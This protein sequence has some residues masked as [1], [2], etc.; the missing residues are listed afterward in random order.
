MGHNIDFSK[1][2]HEKKDNVEESQV[3]SKKDTY[4]DSDTSFDYAMLNKK[5]KATYQNKKTEK[6]MVSKTLEESTD[7]SSKKLNK[8]GRKRK[9]A[10]IQEIMDSDEEDNIG[11]RTV[12]EDELKMKSSYKSESNEENKK[13]KS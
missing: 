7:S 11:T 2:N 10:L 5:K 13:K 8:R 1:K 4:S 9:E 12:L 3:Y 6:P